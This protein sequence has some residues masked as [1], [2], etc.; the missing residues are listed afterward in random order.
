[1]GRSP[2][3]DK[4]TSTTLVAIEISID[5][6]QLTNQT[7]DPLDSVAVVNEAHALIDGLVMKHEMEIIRYGVHGYLC[8]AG[9]P[10]S[11]MSHAKK[12]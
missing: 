10:V 8:A 2:I 12:V 5:T 4:F 6:T 1:M 9:I 3:V 7:H 11:F